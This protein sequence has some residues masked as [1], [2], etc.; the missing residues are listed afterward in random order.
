MSRTKIDWLKAEQ[1]YL[2]NNRLSLMDISQKYG[3][4]YSRVKK[5][6][7]DKGWYQKRQRIIEKGKEQI[8]EEAE[9]SLAEQIKQ[10]RK[11]A[12]YVKNVALAEIKKRAESGHLENE[13]LATLVRM[14]G[15]SLRELRETFPKSLVIEE[16]SPEPKGLS[17]ELEDA[18]NE[19]FERKLTSRKRSKCKE[20]SLNDSSNI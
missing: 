7:M 19:V 4:S 12:T 6:S 20:R 11:D 14:I 16:S 10:H 1:D 9:K 13:S 18:I 3:V 17:Q 5:V 15:I 2:N 8:E